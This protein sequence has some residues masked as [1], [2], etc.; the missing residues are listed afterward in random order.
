[1]PDPF[2]VLATQ[3]PIENEGVYPLPEAQRDRFLMKIVIGY[4]TPTEELEIVQ[5]MGVSPP[6]AS[7]VLDPEDVLRLQA[8][9]KQVYVDQSVLEYA[10]RLVLATR[11]PADHGLPELA[12]QIACG[13]SPRASLGLVAAARALA[14]LRDQP[15]VTPQDVF[16]VAFEVLNHRIVLSYDAMADGVEPG[17]IVH[18]AAVTRPGSRRGAGPAGVGGPGQ[19]RRL[20]RRSARR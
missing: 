6:D 11:S 20:T 3:N 16:D 17:Q 12:G 13:A 14:L 8:A 19:R 9:A 18:T 7:Q 4:P 5:R 10:V 15:Y 1:M 2:L